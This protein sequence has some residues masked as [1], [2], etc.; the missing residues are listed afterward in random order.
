M[1]CRFQ[2]SGVPCRPRSPRLFIAASRTSVSNTAL[3]STDASRGLRARRA[4]ATDEL[5]RR[6]SESVRHGEQ[7]RVCRVEID[8]GMRLGQ[9]EVAQVV[10]E[11]AH[12]P[13]PVHEVDRSIVTLLLQF[14]QPLLVVVEG[15]VGCLLS[16]LEICFWTRLA[17]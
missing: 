6:L 4:S 14:H 10:P 2:V 16:E 9:L 17:M 12:G 5:D 7:I 1:L 11:T 8:L 13:V 3:I 15:F